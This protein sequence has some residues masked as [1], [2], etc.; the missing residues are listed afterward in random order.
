MDAKQYWN[1]CNNIEH[2][3]SIFRDCIEWDVTLL[4]KSKK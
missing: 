4:S 2:M 1:T 3:Q